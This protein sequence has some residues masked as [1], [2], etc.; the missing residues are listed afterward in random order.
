[1]VKYH[2][3]I[4]ARDKEF[5]QLVP[6]IGVK[7][8]TR[9]D[10]HIG[11]Q[12]YEEVGDLTGIDRMLICRVLPEQDAYEEMY[13]GVTVERRPLNGE[14]KEWLN[15]KFRSRVKYSMEENPGVKL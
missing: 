4:V 1:M 7:I 10:G 8:L 9:S 13:T 15:F 3:Y 14:N 5:Q 2:H 6:D 11:A 12:T